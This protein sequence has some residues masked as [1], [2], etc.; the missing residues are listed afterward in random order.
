MW[1]CRFIFDL[2]FSTNLTL[3]RPRLLWRNSKLWLVDR[4]RISIIGFS[5]DRHLFETRHGLVNRIFMH[6]FFFLKSWI[7]WFIVVAPLCVLIPHIYIQVCQHYQPEL[8]FFSRHLSRQ[9]KHPICVYSVTYGQLW[10]TLSTNIQHAVDS[11]S[12][13]HSH[14]FVSY[15]I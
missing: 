10:L 3:S 12:R 14:R 15:I 13:Y 6:P 5:C 7:Y 4:W 9:D 1:V 11:T 8:W 2:V